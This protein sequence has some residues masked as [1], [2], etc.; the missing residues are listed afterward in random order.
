MITRKWFFAPLIIACGV[1]LA[2]CQQ[3]QTDTSGV[4]SPQCACVIDAATNKVITPQQ[5]ISILKSAPV[6]IVGEQHTSAYHHRIEQWLL[7][8]LARA[9]PQGSVLME[10]IDITQQRAV[11]KVKAE[12]Q[13]GAAPSPGRAAATMRWNSGWP[14]PLYRDVVMTAVK[15]DY[16]LLAANISRQQVDGLYRKPN[17]PP[18]ARSAA[19]QVHEALSA[20]I[21]VMHGGQIEGEQVRAMVA[22]QQHRD[23]FM[24]EQLRRAPQPSLLIAGGYHAAKDIG[25][26]LHLQDLRAT[27]PVVVMLTTEGTILTRRQ[28]D[29]I[30]SVPKQK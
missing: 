11:D 14:W 23:R 24:A 13:T 22:I 3:S 1:I 21:Y 26:P 16:P 6:V 18:G 28:A 17:F 29:Y 8:N 12:S 2:A 5:L 4:I 27:A 15:G 20:I 19:P 7:E 9:R 25:V 30:W 10:M